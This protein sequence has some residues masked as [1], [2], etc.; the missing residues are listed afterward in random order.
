MQGMGFVV[1]IFLAHLL[2]PTDFGLIA[3]L[4]VVIA[5]VFTDVEV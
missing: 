4:M 5:Q 3:M 1:T 2:K